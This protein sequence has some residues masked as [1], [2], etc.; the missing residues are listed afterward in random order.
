MSKKNGNIFVKIILAVLSV[1]IK[2]VADNIFNT[3]G[4]EE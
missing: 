3:P 2:E 4:D 1:V